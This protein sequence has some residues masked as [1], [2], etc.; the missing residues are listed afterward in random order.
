[1]KIKQIFDPFSGGTVSTGQN[2][3]AAII[4]IFLLI[5]ACGTW[6]YF[7]TQNINKQ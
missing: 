6:Y 2:S 1:M 7:N 3:K 5:A 4:I